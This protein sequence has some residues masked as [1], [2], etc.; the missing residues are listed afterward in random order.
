MIFEDLKFE[1]DETGE[2]ASHIFPNHYGV[3]VIRGPYTYGGKDG[4]Y[5]LAVLVMRPEDKYSKLCYD[6]PITNDVMGYLT[7]AK[8]SDIM[9]QVSELPERQ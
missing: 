6:T 2:Y 3:S 7:P 4:L 9:K 5:E 8:I 1:T